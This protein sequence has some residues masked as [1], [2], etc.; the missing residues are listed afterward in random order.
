MRL[1]G[2]AQV[3]LTVSDM[4]RAGANS[5]TMCSVR[6]RLEADPLLRWIAGLGGRAF[7]AEWNEELRYLRRAG[8]K[9]KLILQLRIETWMPFPLM[10]RTF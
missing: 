5:A 9:V 10:V 6:F 7:D 8:Q 1:F 3:T 4:M 2:Y